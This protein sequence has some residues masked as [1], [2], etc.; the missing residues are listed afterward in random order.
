MV[1]LSF[2]CNI[3]F[4][5]YWWMDRPTACFKHPNCAR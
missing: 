1:E 5:I 2:L 3:T 4:I